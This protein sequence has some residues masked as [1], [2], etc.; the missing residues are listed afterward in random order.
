MGRITAI[1]SIPAFVSPEEHRDLAASTPTSFSNIPPILR[2]RE[3]GVRVSLDPPLEGW[4]EGEAIEG[5]LYVIESALV[6]SSPGRS[7][8]IEYP[9]ITL[10]AVSRSASGPSIYC[11]LDESSPDVSADNEDDISA[12]RELSIIPKDET[13]LEP[14]FE[15]LSHCASLHPDPNQSDE[16]DLD[17]AFVA[18]DGFETFTGGEDEELSEVGRAALE[19]LESIIYDP[20]EKSE[21]NGMNRNHGGEEGSEESDAKE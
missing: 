1:T 16:D 21:A 4:T 13:S 12:M 7:F 6:F 18:A 2:H 8:Q 14:I 9:A 5:D 20:F 17:D 15:A 11:Q 19:H 3:Q 10:H